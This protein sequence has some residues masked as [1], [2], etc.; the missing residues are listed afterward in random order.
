[1]LAMLLTSGLLSRNNMPRRLAAI[2]VTLYAGEPGRHIEVTNSK[3]TA[4]VY[5]RRRRRGRRPSIVDARRQAQVPVSP[6]DR[7][8]R[9]RGCPVVLELAERG[10]TRSAA[11]ASSR[12]TRF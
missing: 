11:P 7:Q 1:M 10:S 4:R 2:T 8:A 5:S 6:A 12:A 9:A 3:S